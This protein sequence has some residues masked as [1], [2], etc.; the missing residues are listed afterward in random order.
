MVVLHCHSEIA[1]WAQR[2]YPLEVV[3]LLVG[4]RV[5]DTWDVHT[6]VTAI[7]LATT[8]ETQFIL[9]PA[10]WFLAEQTAVQAGMSIVGIIHSH[11][12]A[13]ARP[14][15]RDSAS[16]DSLG[17]DLIFLIISTTKIGVKDLTAWQWDSRQYQEIDVQ[18]T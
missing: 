18:W 13:P 14:S 9:D 5:A 12:D 2:A 10:T 1:V 11:P 4:R 6:L 8:P 7:N 16:G 17:R 3:G 15:S